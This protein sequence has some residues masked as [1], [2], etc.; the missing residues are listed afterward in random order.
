MALQKT[1]SGEL[2]QRVWL[3]PGQRFRSE[4]VCYAD[5]FVVMGKAPAAEMLAAVQHLMAKAKL[6][7][8]ERKTRV[9]RC[10]DEP[11]E[12]VGYRIGW[13]Y[14]RNRGTRYIGTRP[15]AANVQNLCRRVSAQTSPRL[16]GMDT[17]VMVGKLNAMLRGWAAY[18][19]LGQVSP[20]YKAID[21]HT[22][23][24]LRQWLRR[25]HKVKSGGYV[26]FSNLK[27]WNKYGLLQLEPTTRNLPW[28]KV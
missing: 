11:M 28:A 12:F 19:T 10:P 2:Y 24:R 5:D 8:N 18:F 22:T 15:S 7:L 17:E 3:D 21:Q 23:R 25:K 27:L 6:P 16:V 9:L 13:N 1:A 26:H 4:I 14:R 20:A